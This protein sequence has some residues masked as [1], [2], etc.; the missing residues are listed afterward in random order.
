MGDRGTSYSICEGQAGVAYLKGRATETHICWTG[1]DAAELID[2]VAAGISE[3]TYLRVVH[4]NGEISY[5][6]M[7]PKVQET[8]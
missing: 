3:D 8:L 4:L 6:A 7:H 2:E 1:G 5:E